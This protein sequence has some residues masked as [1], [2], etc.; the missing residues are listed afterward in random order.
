MPNPT[1]KVNICHVTTS[2][3]ADAIDLMVPI[4]IQKVQIGRV[5][6]QI[7]CRNASQRKLA[8][9][10]LKFQ[11]VQ[12]FRKIGRSGEIRTPDPL[13]PNQ[14]R[15]QTALHSVASSDEGEIHTSFADRNTKNR[16]SDAK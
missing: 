11:T 10:R 8:P 13:V 16:F 9:A 6:Q 14:M 4:F 5:R 15:Y 3:L 1:G 7:P 12:I 2:K